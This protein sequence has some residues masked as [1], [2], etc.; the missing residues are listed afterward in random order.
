MGK[1]DKFCANSIRISERRSL[2][3]ETDLRHTQNYTMEKHHTE[4]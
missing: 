1:E 3:G 2:K 4:D